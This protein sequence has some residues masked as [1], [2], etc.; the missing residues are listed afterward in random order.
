M[1]DCMTP[2]ERMN[3]FLADIDC[4][5]NGSTARSICNNAGLFY[6][7][8]STADRSCD[9]EL[10]YSHILIRTLE[11]E[12]DQA[13]LTV[14]TYKNIIENKLTN[15]IEKAIE[16]MTSDEKQFRA[17]NTENELLK[18]AN[19]GLQREL[20]ELK[21]A[22]LKLNA[23]NIALRISINSKYGKHI[24]QQN[25]GWCNYFDYDHDHRLHYI[26]NE[27]MLCGKIIN[28][29]LGIRFHANPPLWG[30]HEPLCEEC[31]KLFE[32]DLRGMTNENRRNR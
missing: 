31:F 4:T 1:V 27:K 5:F 32:V 11:L 30:G 14:E 24:D 12:R 17:T 25:E 23:E 22:Y 20:G 18:I 10:V 16:K 21:E 2:I 8:L 26:K 9:L 7:T 28:D 19:T 6:D 29:K 15:A 3:N 13:L